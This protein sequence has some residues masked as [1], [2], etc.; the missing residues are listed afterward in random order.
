MTPRRMPRLA[1]V[2]SAAALAACG[3]G[4]PAPEPSAPPATAGADAAASAPASSTDAAVAAFFEAFYERQLL[5]SPTTLTRIGRRE[6]YGEWGDPSPAYTAQSFALL[7]EAMATR[8]R[9][10]DSAASPQ[11]AL[12]LRLFDARYGPLVEA[13]E[14]WSDYVNAVTPLGV[15][16]RTYVFT[17][18][19]GA[20]AGAPA[21][22]INQHQVANVMEA[23]AYIAR[24]QGVNAYM[25]AQIARSAAAFAKGIHP[26]PFVYDRVIDTAR[27]IIAGAPF[28][29]GEASPLLADFQAKVAA[30]GLKDPER[31][32]LLDAASAAMTA[33][34]QPAYEA[35]IAEMQ[36]QQAAAA[37][38]D[39][40]WKLPD[41][42]AY[43]AWRLRQL[44]TTDLTP[45]QIHDLGLANV[46]RIHAEMR[47]IMAAVGFE[48]ALQ[49]FF[50]FLRNDPQFY[51]D[52][53]DEGRAQYLEAA[54]AAIEAMKARLPEM[55]TR[56]PQADMIVKRVEPFREKSAGKA[57]YQSPALDG[58]R[59]GIYYANLY[60][61]ARM[62]TYQLEALAFHEGIPGHHMENAITQEL[63]GLPLFRRLGNYTVF[64]EG[65]ALYTEKLPKEF[66]FYEDP[67]S[68]FGRLAMELW[69]AARLVVDTGL[70]HKRWTREEAIAY[71]LENTPNP[72][73]DAINAIERYIVMPGQATTY[74]IGS[75]KIQELRAEAAADLGAAFDLRAYHDA[76]LANGPVPLD[77]LEERI[78]AWAAAVKAG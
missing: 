40:V 58:S 73:G 45:D 57:F 10:D 68:D 51:Y 39:G 71:L 61:M 78:D 41:G 1:V 70:H 34:V 15:S 46:A 31:A 27:N 30:L 20:H 9:F 59:P 69:R 76:V 4:A 72:Q 3:P 60:D 11:T 2:L 16:N 75:L 65:W 23:E 37:P 55:F 14:Q 38:G 67:Y 35:L 54:R 13:H 19:G 63:E 12:S 5:R 52:N 77:V 21:F 17:Q 25:E 28:E 26:P 6:R 64:A 74:L 29:E 43:Y 56:L 18:M 42:A 47:A 36:R 44:T 32:R 7:K 50:E 22:L 48:G 66:G 49:D 8:A 33:S 53:T 62:P 24:L